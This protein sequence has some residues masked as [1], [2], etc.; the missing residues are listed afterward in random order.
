MTLAELKTKL[1]TSDLPVAYMSF[2][3]TE[4]PS[5]PFICF[6]ATYTDNFGADGTVYEVIQAAEVQLFTKNKDLTAEAALEGV[7][8]GLYWNKQDEYIEDELCYRVIYTI[9]I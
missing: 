3:E 5:M 6:M 2:P 8:D 1:D 7:L 9:T 4:A